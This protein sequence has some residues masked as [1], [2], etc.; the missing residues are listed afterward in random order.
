MATNRSFSNTMLI[1]SWFYFYEAMKLK[2]IFKGKYSLS[3]ILEVHARLHYIPTL[4]TDRLWVL[5]L[6]VFMRHLGGIVVFA[7]G[8]A[9][10]S[11]RMLYHCLSLRVVIFNQCNA[12]CLLDPQE[13]TFLAFSILCSCPTIN[14]TDGHSSCS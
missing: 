4:V 12:E 10:N 11:L 6:I 5:L 2:N 8:M 1:H 14:T 7:V 3:S 13:S 9:S